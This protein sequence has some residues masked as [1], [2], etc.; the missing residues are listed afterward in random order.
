M[1]SATVSY[2]ASTFRVESREPL[3]ELDEDL[4]IDV[5]RP[6]WDVGPDGRFLM[7]R[8]D[9]GRGASQLVLVRNWVQEVTGGR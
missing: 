7:T 1:W 5:Q 6:V 3:F 2:D 4:T 9:T 8:V